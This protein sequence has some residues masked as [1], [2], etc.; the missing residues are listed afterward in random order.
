MKSAKQAASQP[1]SR[2]PLTR[3]GDR[4]AVCAYYYRTNK[5][6]ERET[7]SWRQDNASER[8]MSP[9]LG[10]LTATAALERAKRIASTHLRE[11]SKQWRF[12]QL[13]VCQQSFFSPVF[14]CSSS[15]FPPKFDSLRQP[16]R[17]A[18]EAT[19][20]E[21]RACDNSSAMAAVWPVQMR[22]IK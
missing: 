9:F 15:F 3:E 2:S 16:G 21:N 13:S 4:I 7:L 14:F 10:T 8:T 18:A 12:L 17:Q 6:P 5:S 20:G 1:A 22:K 11:K 19:G